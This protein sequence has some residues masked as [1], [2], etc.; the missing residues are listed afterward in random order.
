LRYGVSEADVDRLVRTQG[1]WVLHGTGVSGA[2]AGI[3]RLIGTELEDRVA[4]FELAASTLRDEIEHW[5]LPMGGMFVVPDTNVYLH[6]SQHFDEIDWLAE[7]AAALPQ[8][9]NDRLQ[10]T[11]RL[12]VP[13]VV[14]DELDR[15]K[16]VG[17]GRV[18]EDDKDKKSDSVKTRAGKTLARISERFSESTAAT[19]PLN[20]TGPSAGR[21]AIALQMGDPYKARL[22]IA[23]D[24]IIDQARQLRDLTGND[25]VVVTTD[26]GMALRAKAADL[27]VIELPTAADVNRSS[28]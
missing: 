7:I 16:R 6:H 23:D 11:L 4:D 26:R 13:L 3:A 8:D 20:G 28:R 15:Q 5:R 21:V 24:E 22:P 17:N 14:V 1:Y 25:V 9:V 19:P 12:L 27:Q 18:D 2:D 10:R